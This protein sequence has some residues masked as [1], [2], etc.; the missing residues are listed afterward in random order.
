M[1]LSKIVMFLDCNDS[2]TA[3][4]ALYAHLERNKPLQFIYCTKATR[5]SV[6]WAMSTFVSQ[7]KISPLFLMLYLILYITF[8]PNIFFLSYLRFHPLPIFLSSIGL[9]VH[10]FSSHSVIYK[11][12]YILQNPVLVGPLSLKKP[13]IFIS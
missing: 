8:Q 7:F 10:R 12:K 6:S 13:G 2:R 5:I 3:L 9:Q 11:S 1:S 4:Y